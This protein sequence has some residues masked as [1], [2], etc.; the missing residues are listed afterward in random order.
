MKMDTFDILKYW[1]VMFFIWFFVI[2][3]LN[4]IKEVSGIINNG[5]ILTD[6]RC[7]KNCR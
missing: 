1:L 2:I 5:N 4:H 3:I 6:G 7:F